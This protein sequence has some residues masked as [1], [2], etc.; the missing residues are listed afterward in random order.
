MIGKT[1]IDRRKRNVEGHRNMYLERERG[2]QAKNRTS[3][4]CVITQGEQ[5]T[6][7]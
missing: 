7:T 6:Q 2:R 3:I 5:N 1:K 4:S